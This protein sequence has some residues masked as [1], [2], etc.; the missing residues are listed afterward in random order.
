M[1]ALPSATQVAGSNQA[2]Y[3]SIFRQVD[4]TGV[5]K[6]GAVDA[7]AF[8]KRSGL[9]ETA[10]HKIWELSDPTGKGYLDKQGFF[11]SL[12]L[13]ALAQS[14]RDVVLSN[15]T[16]P[17]PIPNMQGSAAAS[18]HSVTPPMTGGPPETSW[19]VS[20]EEKSKYDTIFEG[21]NPIEN[22][23]SGDK[24]RT[25]FMNSNLPVDVL[26]R[27]W[28]LSDIDKDGLLD[29]DEFAVAM[30]L[31]YKAL[32]KE[33]TPM[34]LSPQLMPPAKRK[35]P[36]MPGAVG[37]LPPG[38]IP[39]KRATP[40]IP[41]DGSPKGSPVLATKQEQSKWVVTSQEKTNSDAIFQQIDT[42]KD[43]LV[44]GEEIRPVLINS[45]LPQA[46]L[47]QIW[48]LCDTKQ[49][50]QLNAEQFALAMYLVAQAQSGTNPPQALTPEMV[51]P[52]LRPKPGKAAAGGLQDLAAGDFSA[53]KELDAISKEIESLSKE[54]GQLQINIRTKEEHVKMKTLEVQGLQSELEKSTLQTRQL[55]TQKADA[56]KR[57]G[58]LDQQRTK[59]EA[60]LAEVKQ[61]CQE[62]QQD[63]DNLKN[64]ISS[65]ETSLKA[66]EEELN[67]ARVELTTLRQEEV[68]LEQQLES[69]KTHL[70]LVVQSTKG[71][72]QELQQLQTKLKSLVE[73][74]NKLNGQIL[75]FEAPLTSLAP[76]A[77]NN[78]S[79]VLQG[80]EDLGLPHHHNRLPSTDID[81]FS[82]RATA[83]NSPVSSV[84]GFSVSSELRQTDEEFKEDPFKGRDPFANFA[85]ASS[86]DPFQSQDPFKD[87]P[88]KSDSFSSD[89]FGADPFKNST[90]S[91]P[92]KDSTPPDLFHKTATPDPF[93]ESTTPDPFKESTTPDPFKT[94]TSPDPF[95][96][97]ATPDPFTNSTS[98][99]PFPST[100]SDPFN[101]KVTP[102]PFSDMNSD[103]FKSGDPFGSKT[104]TD[105]PFASSATPGAGAEN[106]FKSDDPFKAGGSTKTDGFG[107]VDPFGGDA[108]MTNSTKEGFAGDTFNFKEET[109]ALPP[110]K[111]KT[112]TSSSK[113]STASSVSSTTTA[114]VS[115]V[116]AFAS[117]G[118]ESKPD[119]FASKTST[120]DPF[121][122]D[123]FA[124]F[125]APAST[126]AKEG[127]AADPFASFADFGS[128][129]GNSNKASGDA[130]SWLIDD[131]FSSGTKKQS[132]QGAGNKENT[133]PLL[134]GD[135]FAGDV[136]NVSLEVTPKGAS[137]WP[138]EDT[139]S[140][141]KEK[142][143]PLDDSSKSSQG[144]SFSMDE[145][146]SG[147]GKETEGGSNESSEEGFLGRLAKSSRVKF[148]V[149]DSAWPSQE[150]AKQDESKSTP[151]DQDKSQSDGVAVKTEASSSEA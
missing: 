53:I 15:L 74:K 141:S 45:G 60:L 139:F 127:G 26:S 1:A 4:K 151:Q 40:P 11:V 32:E 99:D 82:N 67:S 137:S 69:G 119:P 13:I 29:K 101:S 106:L 23:L 110:K 125:A 64:Q 16:V 12:K 116:D 36:P 50:G 9:R 134:K 100:S 47:A 94:S 78:Q 62:T 140:S 27:I 129:K 51:P 43:G 130:F 6:I 83:G 58:E 48:N 109:P 63:V 147:R 59:L 84:S 79:G 17:A 135:I 103:P 42:D 85:D 41:M 3:E 81:A 126:N 115:N 75:Q 111:S 117:F 95:K 149:G 71:V 112:T 123:P 7:A 132:D 2:A 143:S 97:S 93:K 22:K 52:T 131:F 138:E 68:Q 122:G 145:D 80:H 37:V 124:G 98:S 148:E 133:S 5:G 72:E 128:A 96:D 144:V 92:F 105:D 49:T 102:D 35:K 28:D 55:E 146:F 66:Q 118:G 30:H 14:G 114:S 87:D 113:A 46:I 136:K 20:P 34:V 44:G 91:D 142:M 18:S 8:L 21:L 77:N 10:L 86:S 90:T 88:F 120:S 121:G 70:D 39:S 57:L 54:K 56:E 24:V 108:F 76:H 104:S 38:A 65:Q 31:V 107:S 89:P 150:G 61:Q 73:S 19:S 33:P 25:V